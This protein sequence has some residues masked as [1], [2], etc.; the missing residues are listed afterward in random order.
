[1]VPSMKP[2]EPHP[3]ALNGNVT[4][5]DAL[6]KKAVKELGA[7]AIDGRTSLAKELEGE[8]RE[9]ISALGGPSEVSP[10][11][12][13]IVEMIAMKRVRRKPIA[14]WALLNRERLLDRRKRSLVPIALQLEQLEESEVRL[15][16]ELGLKRRAKPLP[17]LTDYLNGNSEATKFSMGHASP[18]AGTA[19][20]HA[21]L[22][23]SD[24]VQDVEDG[25][26]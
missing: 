7:R 1:M 14:Q 10:Q 8:R 2:T 26:G 19:H 3:S 13:A 11:E 21:P 17:S 6:L 5:G 18:S 25:D 15:L 4:H 9:L 16:K 20:L 23:G 24:P 22:G 12:L